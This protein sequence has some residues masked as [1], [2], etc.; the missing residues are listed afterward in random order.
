MLLAAAAWAEPENGNGNGTSPPPG[1]RVNLFDARPAVLDP[2]PS[3]LP[4]IEIWK[5]RRV[6]ELRTG[7]QVIRQ[8]QVALGRSP[9]S[10]KRIRGDTRTPVG[11]YFI[12][13][14]RPASNY[15]R[16]LGI[17]YPNVDDAE[18]GYRDRIISAH[19]WV[20]LFITNLRAK[21]PTWRTALGGA[22]GIH[23]QGG[24]ARSG[25]WTKG[26]IAVSDE[27]ID[28]IYHR[29]PLGTAVIINE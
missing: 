10:T 28:F 3:P 5:Q 1:E 25:D 13:S 14:K 15:H 16:F 24:V 12:S 19:E 8:F 27:E 2:R 7:D 17:N 9:E 4:V 26:C 11:H 22:V 18:R 21:T 6:M 29:V 23:G 20:D